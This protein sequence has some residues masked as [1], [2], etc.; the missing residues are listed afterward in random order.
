[1]SSI[2]LLPH[3]TLADLEHWEDR[4]E[5]IRGIPHAMTPAPRIR[6]Q[7][8]LGYLF[9]LMQDALEDCADC[10]AILEP[11]VQLADDTLLIPDLVVVCGELPEDALYLDRSPALVAEVLSPSTALKDRAV[12]RDLYEA[13]GIKLY[14][15]VDP[16]QAAVELLAHDGTRYRPVRLTPGEPVTLDLGP[17]SLSTDFSHIWSR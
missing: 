3:Y 16:E 10:D 13:Q 15:L 6:H 14:L 12:K 7:Q 17:C 9:T 1:M 11:N 5:L 2:T 4:W 8:T